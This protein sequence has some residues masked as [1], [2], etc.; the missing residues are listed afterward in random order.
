MHMQL[1][2]TQNGQNILGCTREGLILLISILPTK[3]RNNEVWELQGQTQK[4][5]NITGVRTRAQ[6]HGQ[7][8][9][10]GAKTILGSKDQSFE[11]TVPSPSGAT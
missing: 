5:V 11:Q 10:Q 1:Q 7:L 9:S 8:T 3:Q 2:D 6:I 4:R